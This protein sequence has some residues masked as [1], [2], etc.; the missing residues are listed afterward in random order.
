MNLSSQILLVC[1]LFTFSII[2]SPFVMGNVCIGLRE[3]FSA[4]KF[5]KLNLKKGS[6]ISQARAG[7][8]GVGGVIS[9][10]QR[11]GA[12]PAPSLY[13]TWLQLSSAKYTCLEQSRGQLSDSWVALS[14]DPLNQIY[15]GTMKPL[16]KDLQS[17][18]FEIAAQTY[19][20]LNWTHVPYH[21]CLEQNLK[22][23]SLLQG[24]HLSMPVFYSHKI[25][26]SE[27]V[28]SK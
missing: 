21:H 27:D 22:K 24:A 26:C 6:N 10:I 2:F 4:Q 9:C 13:F 11:P 25:F 3:Y 28:C 16:G 1:H 18:A 23:K 7:G 17:P 14:W 15:G 8:G 12:L 19:K 20:H 5:R